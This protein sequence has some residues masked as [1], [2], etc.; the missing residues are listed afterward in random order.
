M[1]INPFNNTKIIDVFP[2]SNREITLEEIVSEIEK[3][4]TKT[5]VGNF[6]VIELTEED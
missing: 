2:G 3:T 6:E 5:E 1:K 4:L